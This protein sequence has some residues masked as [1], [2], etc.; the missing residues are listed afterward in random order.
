MKLL[1]RSQAR[2]LRQA[3]W[4]SAT[5]ILGIVLGVASVV[6]VH[7]ISVRISDS[8][9]A[10]TPGYLS[11]LSFMAE[12]PQLRMSDY[13]ALRAAWRLGEH[14]DIAGMVPIVEGRIELDGLAV[15]VVGVDAFSGLRSMLPMAA[16]PFRGLIATRALMTQLGHELPEAQDS[17]AI[18]L[19][20]G[21]AE[22][23]VNAVVD[24][25]EQRLLLT[26]LGTAQELLGLADDQLSRVGLKVEQPFA[27][28]EA[29]A[30]QLLPGLGAGF[31]SGN[32]E[33]AGWQVRG[34]DTELPSQV[35]GQSVLFNLGAL[36]SLALVVAWLLVYQVALIWLRRRR[37]TMA[38]LSFLGV[39]ATEL[40]RGFCL[41][42]GLLALVATAAGL[43]V[44]IVLARVLQQISTAGLGVA[45]VP[46]T[47]DPWVVGKAA[48][49]GLGVS[50]LG[51]MLAFRAQQRAAEEPR[52]RFML[53]LLVLLL[54][55][56]AFG[57]WVIAG[58]W[59]AFLA[60]VAICLLAIAAIVP[61]LGLLSN[62]ARRL[63]GISLLAAIGGRELLKFPRDLAVAIAAL[64]LAV[65]TS[66]AIGL[67]VDS[68]RLD[69][70]RMLDHRLADDV[71]IRA[72]GRDI[73]AVAQA[74]RADPSI[75]AVIPSG[76]IRSRVN[77]RPVELGYGDFDERASARYGRSTALTSGQG[78]A[79]EKLLRLTSAATGD[80]L[81]IADH[82]VIVAGSFPGFGDVLPRLLVNLETAA[83]V[84]QV[85]I[86]SLQFDR[87]ALRS[88]A[89]ED[90]A[91]RLAV[92]YPDL[93]VLL[94]APLR[95]LALEIFDQTFAITGAL[96]LLALI[97]ACIG[98]YN[99]L[100]GLRLIQQ[101]TARLLISMGVSRSE[102]RR[103]ALARGLAI[104]AAVLLFALPL[105]L[106]MGWLLCTE[107]N[108]RAFGWA[109]PLVVSPAAVAVPALSGLV[110]IVLTSLLPAPGERLME[111]T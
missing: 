18:A 55:A 78:L 54:I 17:L 49:S 82:Q 83:M 58:L 37:R 40:R 11:E 84:A 39:T 74:L 64:T 10:T 100:L 79:S 26:D 85:S 77:G 66:I 70:A 47:I 50:L 48:V 45:A 43:G 16:L 24:S 103:I 51:A 106:V 101:P 94:A 9:S 88:S 60:I 73:S 69:F 12:K 14:A 29:L 75:N 20:G 4:S 76:A 68:F 42:L 102:N 35:F 93:E 34:I 44:G 67:M 65:A 98:L 41:S 31:E 28:L 1:A 15:S 109:V 63:P 104:G 25:G 2:F 57:V 30:N 13:F 90:L 56:A 96:T 92:E 36:G 81:R 86:D 8:L 7:L 89:P 3:P 62:S 61:A 80:Q 99:A 107:V 59:G 71:Y 33:L 46:V 72:A 105:G 87:L 27:R 6:A 21:F 53:L 52:I 91:A 111:T 108:P 32:W 5:V 19:P 110:V 38:M 97:V 95:N 22:F 23:E